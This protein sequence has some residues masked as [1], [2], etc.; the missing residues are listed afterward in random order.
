MIVKPDDIIIFRLGRA[1]VLGT[2]VRVTDNQIYAV[3]DSVE[4]NV[5]MRQ[6]ELHQES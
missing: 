2:V 3:S 5:T 1:A 6:I 4:Y